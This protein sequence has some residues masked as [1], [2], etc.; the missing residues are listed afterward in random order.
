M[1]VELKWIAFSAY[2]TG[3]LLFGYAH[4][5]NYVDKIKT[6]TEDKSAYLTE[7]EEMS[8]KLIR[9]NMRL[10]KELMK[11]KYEN[12]PWEV[13]AKKM[14]KLCKEYEVTIRA[15]EELAKNQKKEIILL[16]HK[17]E[18]LE[19]KLDWQRRFSRTM[20]QDISFGKENGEWPYLKQ[21]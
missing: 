21:N 13:E 6:A 1:E 16:D 4:G 14:S 20:L 15:Y 7:I 12:N 17:I 3:C 18:D 2:T 10:N 9:E 8:D 19:Y 5:Y 11:K